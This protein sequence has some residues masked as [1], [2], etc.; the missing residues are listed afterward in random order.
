MRVPTRV[1]FA[2][3]HES[4]YVQQLD[5]SEEMQTGLEQAFA[6]VMRL[7]LHDLEARPSGIDLFV[8]SWRFS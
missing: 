6:M 2:F 7:Q 5:N 3:I 1:Y 8:A 4:M